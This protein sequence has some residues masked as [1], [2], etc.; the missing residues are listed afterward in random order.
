MTI[1]IVLG[2]IATFCIFRHDGDK[3]TT[4]TGQILLK[5][6]LAHDNYFDQTAVWKAFPNGQMTK[7]CRQSE[8][9]EADEV[10]SE[11]VAHREEVGSL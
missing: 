5:R 7:W 1:N 10:F 11:E 8:K 3:T 2:Q 4:M 9:L 6:E